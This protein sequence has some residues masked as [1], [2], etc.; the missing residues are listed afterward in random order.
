M[1]PFFFLAKELET[2]EAV[3][4]CVTILCVLFSS[5]QKLFSLSQ[6]AGKNAAEYV[7]NT[8][9]KYFTK[10]YAE[11]HVPVSLHCAVNGTLHA[12][13]YQ[14]HHNAPQCLRAGIYLM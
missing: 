2:F 11:P 3:C 14:V 4:L 8:Y 1:V 6:E 5:P 9:P 13:A 12:C 7:V 10:D